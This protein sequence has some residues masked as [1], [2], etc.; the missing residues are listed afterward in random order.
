MHHRPPAS[1]YLQVEH[2]LLHFK[3]RLPGLSA[4]KTENFG[5]TVV[6]NESLTKKT[7]RKNMTLVTTNFENELIQHS[8]GVPYQALGQMHRDFKRIATVSTNKYKIWP[9]RDDGNRDNHAVE[10]K[11]AMSDEMF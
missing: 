4:G 3:L 5:F 6:P 11:R 10:S 1:D 7:G 2:G 9:G 8:T